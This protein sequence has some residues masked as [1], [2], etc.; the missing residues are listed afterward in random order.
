MLAFDLMLENLELRDINPR[1][2]GWENCVS[3]HSYGPAARSYW[4]LHFVRSGKGVF[5]RDGQCHPVSKGEIF[6]IRPGEVTTYRADEQEPW[7]Y[8]WLGFDAS[9]KLPSCLE[10]P[11][12]AADGCEHIFGSLLHYTEGDGNNELYVCAKIYELLGIL[13]QRDTPAHQ[14]IHRYVRKAKNYMKS[15]YTE[16]ISV[17]QMARQ[18]GLDRSYFCRIFKEIVGCPPNQYLVRLRLERAAELIAERG[19]SPAEAAAGCG[20]ADTVNFSR[21]FSRHF[22]VPPSRYGKGQPRL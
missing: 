2:C 18:L 5:E 22:G 9:I 15:S 21:M 10:Q 17:Q 13:S 8:S 19:Y 6:V 1:I 20:Y 16:Q 12:V 7:Q 14:Q 3:G 11:V 4:L